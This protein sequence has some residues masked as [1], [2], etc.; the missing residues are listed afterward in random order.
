MN[1]SRNNTETVEYWIDRVARLEV[2]IQ[3]NVAW[4]DDVEDRFDRRV[5]AGSVTF[6]ETFNLTSALYSSGAPMPEVVAA[7][8]RLL[9]DAYPRFVAL[10]REAPDYARG[11]YGGGWDFRTRYLAMAVLC[12]LPPAQNLPLVEAIDFWP[13]RDAVWERFIA[14][15]GHGAGRPGVTSL[16]WPQAYAPLLEAMDPEG[17]ELTRLAALRLFLNG[18]LKQMRVSTNPFY[19]NEKNKNNTYVGHWCF[20]A[21]AAALAFGIDDTILRDHEHYPADWADWARMH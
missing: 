2:R 4:R 3:K 14:A 17:T 15:L 21:A 19:S 18:W 8:Q 10:C 11:A 16:V 13:E 7:A 20:E 6:H 9:L 12:R 1:V 5:M